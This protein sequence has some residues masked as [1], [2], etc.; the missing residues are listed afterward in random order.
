[1]D[2]EGHYQR[3]NTRRAKL[4]CAQSE[5]IGQLADSPVEQV[6][7]ANVKLP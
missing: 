3:K 1:M 5:L 4:K 6:A 7:K 2:G